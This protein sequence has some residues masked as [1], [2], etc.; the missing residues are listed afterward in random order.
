MEDLDAAIDERPGGLEGLRG[1]VAPTRG[2][3]SQTV[4]DTLREAILDGALEAGTWLREAEVAR[5]LKVSRTPVRDA[6][7]VLATEGLVTM[8]ANQGVVVAEMTSDDVTEMYAAREA[9]EAVSARLAARRAPAKCLEEFSRLLPEMKKAA[10][11]GRIEHLVK[12]NFQFHSTIR[13]A[14][15]NRYVNRALLQIQNAS[16][17]FH[18]ATLSLPGRME[19]SIDEHV[20]LADAISRG[21]EDLAEEIALEH[22]RHLSELRIRM[23]LRR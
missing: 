13:E 17:R 16:R 2:N 3:M 23:L 20:R 4:A 1:N 11:E 9:L 18:D 7:R 8:R 15:G 10:E 22:M 5:E 6:F 21:D 19:Q 12:L 14:S